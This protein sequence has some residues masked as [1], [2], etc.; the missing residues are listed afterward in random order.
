MNAK[1]WKQV[2]LLEMYSVREHWYVQ[3]FNN[4]WLLLLYYFNNIGMQAFA[5]LQ[6]PAPPIFTHKQ[7]C[8][9]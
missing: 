6:E 8:T 1:K 5:Y 2:S 7:A 9:M 3:S 4:V